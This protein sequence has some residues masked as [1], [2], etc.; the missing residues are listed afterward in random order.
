MSLDSVWKEASEDS[1][2]VNVG[3]QGYEAYVLYGVKIVRDKDSGA[4]VIL[5]TNGRRSY[6]SMV[7]SDHIE[8]F[9]EK[10]WRHGVYVVALSIFR[11]KLDKIQSLI[12]DE[13]N[14]RGRKRTVALHKSR[15][16]EV[17]KKYNELKSKLDYGNS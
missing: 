13:V 14:G 16:D 1:H 2:A 15:R 9:I 10:G 4:I 17:L 6:Y 5:S 8:S 3:G 11:S 12:R 7:S